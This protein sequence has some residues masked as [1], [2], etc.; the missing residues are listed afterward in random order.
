[1]KRSMISTISKSLWQNMR[2][3]ALIVSVIV[4]SISFLLSYVNYREI[5]TEKILDNGSSKYGSHQLNIYDVSYSTSQKITNDKNL[6]KTTL[7][8]IGSTQDQTGK[9]I[10]A[11]DEIFELSN[12]KLLDGEFPGSSSEVLC[13]QKYLN[14]LGV[15]FSEEKS[16]KIDIDGNQYEV[17]GLIQT[18]DFLRI[19]GVYIPSFVFNYNVTTD[20]IDSS[21]PLYSVL[22]TTNNNITDERNR[23]IKE[24]DLSG[25][26][27]I[28]NNNVLA[29]A[30]ID[31][32]GQSTDVFLLACDYLIYVIL[33]FM[34]LLFVSLFS[35]VCKRN[36]R[37]IAIYAAIGVSTKSIL[38]SVLKILLSLFLLIGG[39]LFILSIIVSAV[40]LDQFEIWDSIA[41]NALI[42]LPYILSTVLFS[43]ISFVRLFPKDISYALSNKDDISKEKTIKRH[44][45]STLVTSRFPFW[46]MASL[47]VS[48]HS[49]KQAI[50]IVGL[51]VAMVFTSLFMY[52]SHYIFIDSGEYQYDY[53]VDYTYSSF[54]DERNG[55]ESNF[56]KYVQMKQHPDLFDTYSFFYQVHPAKVKKSNLSKPFVEFLRSS[57]AYSFKELDHIDNSLYENNFFIIGAD[58][59]QMKNVYK[60]TGLSDYT[61]SDNE[62]IIVKN[63]RT[64]DGIGFETGFEGNDTF[65]ITDSYYIEDLGAVDKDIAMTIKEVVTDINLPLYNCY[66]MPIIIV[67]QNVFSQISWYKYDYPQQI[68][69]NSKADANHIYDFFK[70][71]PDIVITDLTTEKAQLNEQRTILGSV[72]FSSCALLLLVLVMNTIISYMDKFQRNQKQIATLKSIGV[73]NKKLLLFLAY[74]FFTTTG[75]AIL[76]GMGTSL[77]ACY[78]SHFYI[79]KTLF[80]FTFEILPLVY[81]IPVVCVILVT[82]FLIFWFRKTLTQLDIIE[83]L[84][85][86]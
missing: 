15:S 48:L 22:C 23:I 31:S 74:E 14:Q 34:A 81:I 40:L 25:Q 60:I 21:K 44:N 85:R 32:N 76:F 73:C 75:L 64:P 72:V 45:E 83:C 79:R 46:K 58:E 61:L 37:T 52:I 27:V 24:Y 56:Q 33:G 39:V 82:V 86:E 12:I 1:M 55:T 59:E 28:Y 9:K 84:Q 51:V 6:T 43:M 16:L 71:C 20:E 42:V 70:G 68:Y 38:I 8:Y 63:V 41:Q 57:S 5:S 65:F 69:F 4:L 54:L 50:A 78:I 17:S 49:G 2:P 62:C 19:V 77:G 29:Y 13:E 35:L 26:N 67:N 7:M 53:R 11:T 3:K 10:Y 80:F 30:S 66:Y 18:N 47:N 36:K